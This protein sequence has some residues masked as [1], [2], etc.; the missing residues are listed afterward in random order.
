MSYIKN[1]LLIIFFLLIFHS[2]VNAN[3][4]D[5]KYI[6][7]DFPVLFQHSNYTG[8]YLKLTKSVGSLNET[9]F[10][11][12]ASSLCVPEGWE[13]EIYKDEGYCGPNYHITGPV[14]YGDLKTLSPDI[15]NWNDS[16]N[17]VKVIPPDSHDILTNAPFGELTVKW[18]GVVDNAEGTGFPHGP[19]GNLH[20][21][22][23]DSH[24]VCPEKQKI[25]P[26]PL[27]HI[28]L[29]GPNPTGKK[30]EWDDGDQSKL[31]SLG[32]FEWRSNDDKVVVFIYESDGKTH[33]KD[34]DHDP[35][36]CQTVGRRETLKAAVFESNIKAND[37]AIERAMH[38]N[39]EQWLEIVLPN[40][41]KQRVGKMF[42]ELETQTR[43]STYNDR[44]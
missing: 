24:D 28:V 29:P 33:G 7:R 25:Y 21:L 4:E 2:I 42:I 19:Y 39:A 16:I 11:S 5:I 18:A 14:N 26:S 32:L 8:E 15:T 1:I 37:D 13:L 40:G 38:R 44:K 9:G 10:G 36:F 6:C 20:I 3:P 27:R 43:A 35:V 34:W 17:S 31:D 30:C 41:L 12:K 22:I 23:Y